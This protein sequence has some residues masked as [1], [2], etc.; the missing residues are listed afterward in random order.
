VFEFVVLGGLFRRRRRSVSA[1]DTSWPTA[2]KLC[3]CRPSRDAFPL[4]LMTTFSGGGEDMSSVY[5]MI[6]PPIEMWV[7]L[8]C[9]ASWSGALLVQGS[10][11]AIGEGAS[12]P[13]ISP[14]DVAF[15]CSFDLLIL[16]CPSSS[17][18]H[19]RVPALFPSCLLSRV[20]MCSC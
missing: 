11:V 19:C 5:V 3:G 1:P 14:I 16:P 8:D 17:S 10:I 15:C 6:G 13:S 7:G 18:G 4:T 12:L 9:A 2:S 20:H